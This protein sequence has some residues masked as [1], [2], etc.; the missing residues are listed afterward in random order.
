MVSFR[1]TMGS[2]AVDP[3]RGERACS[4]GDAG[5]RG[6]VPPVPQR[7]IAHGRS[8]ARASSPVAPLSLLVNRYGSFSDALHFS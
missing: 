2:G 1:K 8:V 5:G 7:W 3:F 6:A 4:P